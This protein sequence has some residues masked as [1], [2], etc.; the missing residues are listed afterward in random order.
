MKFNLFSIW[1]KDKE[2]CKK[3][4]VEECSD[5][6]K[7][8]PLLI[9]DDGKTLIKC[10]RDVVECVIPNGVE[11][12][13]EEA[14]RGHQELISVTIPDSVIEIGGGAFQGCGLRTVTLPDS[15]TRL[16]TRTFACCRQLEEINLPESIETICIE[17]FNSCESLQHLE[18][19]SS[20][21]EIEE[22]AISN[23]TRLQVVIINSFTVNI[24]NWAFYDCLQLVC[25]ETPFPMSFN[26]K[27]YK[28]SKYLHIISKHS[29]GKLI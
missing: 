21:K 26:M 18:I 20:V 3:N 10:I 29:K 11:V 23:C 6:D 16:E 4:V 9:S 17:A 8:N 24:H 27:H 1:K 28:C 2:N 13:A 12:I 25:I 7:N 22:Y 15:I 14:F 19:P 5:V